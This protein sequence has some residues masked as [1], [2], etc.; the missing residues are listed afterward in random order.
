MTVLLPCIT[1]GV[2]YAD[3][4]TIIGLINSHDEFSYKTEVQNLV[5]SE[6][7]NL[8]LSASKTKK[9]I[10]DFRC[11]KTL[12]LPVTISGTKVEMVSSFKCLGVTISNYLSWHVNT[13]ALVRKSLQRL[14]YMTVGHIHM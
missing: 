7:N 4:S 13:D 10:S 11:E 12:C 14:I 1:T 3:G 2:K 6:A 8:I 9:L 5:K